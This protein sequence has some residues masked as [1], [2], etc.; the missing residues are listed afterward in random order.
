MNTYLLLAGSLHASRSIT[1]ILRLSAP[2][3]SH[4]LLSI[5]FSAYLV[6]WLSGPL[7]TLAVERTVSSLSASA[8]TAV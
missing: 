1:I 8:D 6:G 5:I 4:A 7:L 3:S 2:V